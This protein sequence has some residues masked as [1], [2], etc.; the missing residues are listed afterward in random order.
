MVLQA[1]KVREL[2][3][4]GGSTKLRSQ[5][6]RYQGQI[7]WVGLLSGLSEAVTGEASVCHKELGDAR[8]TG[9]IVRRA[10]CSG[11]ADPRQ[12]THTALGRAGGRTNQ[13]H[14]YM[15]LTCRIC[16]AG[17]QSVGSVLNPCSSLRQ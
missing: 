2:Q 12:V 10:V 4:H 13:V 16:P 7:P 5:E 9:R 8:N 17:V 14:G 15:A 1:R 11:G 3:G 6:T